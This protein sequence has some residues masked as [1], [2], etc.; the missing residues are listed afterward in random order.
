MH[1][2]VIVGEGVKPGVVAKGALEHQRLGRIDVPFEHQLRFGRHGQIRRQRPRQLDRLAADEAG[3]EKFVDSGRQ[4]RGAGVDAGRVAAEGNH[5]GHPLS[6][7]RHLSPVAGAH[8]VTLPVHGERVPSQDLNPV[9]AD[10]ANAAGGIG[11]DHHRKGDVSS[12]VPG[13]GGEKRNAAQIDLLIPLH[14]LLTRR[15]PTFLP[16]REL[17]DLGQFRQHRQLAE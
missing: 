11:G 15:S 16:R 9:H 7:R 1:L 17:A 13:P 3:K 12:A 8:L 14:H 4:R 6:P 2:R 10:V 5:H